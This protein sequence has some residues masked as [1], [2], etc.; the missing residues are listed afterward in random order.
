M[1]RL[2]HRPLFMRK[3]KMNRTRSRV[4]ALNASIASL[5]LVCGCNGD[6]GV[7][8]GAGGSTGSGPSSGSGPLTQCTEVVDSVAI[9]TGDAAV[10][11]IAKM[12]DGYAV[13]LIAGG[14]AWLIMIDAEASV[15]GSRQL[16]SSGGTAE[17][18]SVHPLG[19]GMVALWAQGS[20]VLA[21]AIDASGVPSADATM[22]A[23]TTSGEPRPAGASLGDSVAVAWMDGIGSV[24]GILGGGSLSQETT[25]PGWF[26]SVAASGQTVGVA[27]SDGA[28]QGPLNIA[29]LDTMASPTPLA[30][31]SSLI[32]S[33]ASGP[34][35]FFVAWEEISSGTEQIGLAAIDLAQ[36]VLA[37]T[38][39]SEGGTSA[40]WPNLAWSGDRLAITYYQFRAGAPAVFVTFTDAALA[41]VGNEVTVAENAKYPSLAWGDGEVAIAYSAQGEGGPIE[42]SIV[43]CP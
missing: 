25:V 11:S 2:S 33:L 36:G 3:M 29:S 7:G 43:R 14:E 24:A 8:V 28:E 23:T 4:L 13:A 20:D 6:D 15:V 19:S 18:P 30:E 22:L 12:G 1:A 40:N 10:P 9:V 21:R 5:A 34:D 41:P 16:S 26:P 42:V 37:E 32:K 35:G 17:L 31:T 27:W 39:I 38:T